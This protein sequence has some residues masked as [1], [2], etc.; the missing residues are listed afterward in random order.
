LRTQSGHPAED[1]RLAAQ[2]IQAV[3][4][5]MIGSEITE[6]F[7]PRGSDEWYQD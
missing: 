6:E 5:G 2:L 1:V 4:L 7:A 3:D